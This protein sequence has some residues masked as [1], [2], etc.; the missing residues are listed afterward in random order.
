MAVH[1]AHHLMAPRLALPAH[2]SRKAHASIATPNS[3]AKADQLVA[4]V[5]LVVVTADAV[6]S[7][8]KKATANTFTLA[9]L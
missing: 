9:N 4:V 2:A 8:A 5:A 7:P 3:A 1:P 6:L